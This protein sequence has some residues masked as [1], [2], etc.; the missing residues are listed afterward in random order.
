MRLL[1]RACSL[2][3]IRLRLSAVIAPS[4]GQIFLINALKNGLLAIQ[5]PGEQINQLFSDASVREGFRLGIDLGA[6]TVSYEDSDRVFRFEIDPFIKYCLHN[7]LDEIA[8][9]LQYAG[10]IEDYERQRAVEH[11]WVFH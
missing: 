11:P 6:Q 9:T 10:E 4:F 1:S 3:L 8:L 5:L 2:G 7:G